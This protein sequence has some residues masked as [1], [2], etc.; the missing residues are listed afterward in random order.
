MKISRPIIMGLSV[1]AL[2]AGLA[3]CKIT[4][5]TPAPSVPVVMN[6]GD[7]VTFKVTGPPT[8]GPWQRITSPS[9]R[10][11]WYTW[12]GDGMVFIKE[13]STF[14]YTANLGFNNS[15]VPLTNRMTLTCKLEKGYYIP[16]CQQ[17]LGWN[18]SEID[19]RQWDVHI[20]Q[21]SSTWQGN[22][23]IS[24]SSDIEDMK[25]YTAVNGDLIISCKGISNLSG[26]PSGFL[27]S[28]SVYIQDSPDLESLHGMENLTFTGNV[29]IARNAF[30]KN[31][32][33]FKN[34]TTFGGYI[35]IRNNDTLSSLDGLQNIVSVE[36]GIYI[37]GNNIL[38]SL[39]GLYRLT[40]VGNNL[41]IIDNHAL[42][43]LGMASLQK[44][45]SD[46]KIYDN[47]MLC[48]SL[49]EEL[50]NQVLAADGIGGEIFIERNKEC[51]TP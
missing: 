9:L 31:L 42:T 46:F 44:V 50:M 10:Y 45:G 41:F 29:T 17:N 21:N 16:C 37:I 48:N 38:T 2:I 40:S 30:L 24:D 19:R 33:G 35:D 34:I 22:Y 27:I 3:G 5:A 18:W 4:G 36:D 25:R 43:T 15:H 26:I 49:A 51:T 7:T 14:S 47:P 13:G 11:A 1:L 20:Y 32:S 28:G 23:I 12:Y 8:P 39:A 6:L